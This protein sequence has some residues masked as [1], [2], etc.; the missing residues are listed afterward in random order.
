MEVEVRRALGSDL[1]AIAEIGAE[2]FSGLRPVDRARDWVRA[3]AA[4]APRMEYWVAL[5]DGRVVAYI[6][7]ME[8]GG[9]RVESVWELEQIAVRA[10]E[11]RLG[12]GAELIRRSLHGIEEELARRGA[13]LK[14]VEV[15]TGTEQSAV[16]FYRRT[17]G[18]E[19]VAKLPAFFRGDELILVSR[20]EPAPASPGG[21]P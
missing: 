7:W 15:T 17:L 9:F 4:A 18:A 12:I 5:R 14:L 20:R 1:G 16:E 2:A 13:R 21:T 3:C 10:S 6:L 11:R 19:V 8:K